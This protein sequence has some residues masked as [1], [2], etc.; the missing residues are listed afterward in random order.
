MHIRRGVTI[1]AR[2]MW[3]VLLF[4]LLQLCGRAIQAKFLQVNECYTEQR[5]LH[6][7][8]LGPWLCRYECELLLDNAPHPTHKSEYTQILSILRNICWIQYFFGCFFFI[9]QS[10]PVS[11]LLGETHAQASNCCPHV[12]VYVFHLKTSFVSWCSGRVVLI[13]SVTIPIL[14]CIFACAHQLRRSWCTS[15]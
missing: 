14:F 7:T 4:G 3:S 9:F 11:V 12:S 13:L 6:S 10:V 2:S 5:S 15:T 8:W 1:V